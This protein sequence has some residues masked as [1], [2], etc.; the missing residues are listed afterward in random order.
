[1]PARHEQGDSPADGVADRLAGAGAKPRPADEALHERLLALTEPS[2]QTK[3]S[4]WQCEIPPLRPLQGWLAAQ[5]GPLKAAM[6]AATATVSSMHRYAA[7]P[8]KPLPGL[9]M[10]PPAVRYAGTF[11]LTPT[12]F[13]R[14]CR[15]SVIWRF[16]SSN[17]IVFLG[18]SARRLRG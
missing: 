14:A 4:P 12:A 18:K 16:L 17:S 5:A 3:V 15:S 8:P 10:A 6:I 9:A 1:V 11:T 13:R 7:R 2:L